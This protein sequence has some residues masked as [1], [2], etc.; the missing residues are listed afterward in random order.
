MH[1]A[2]I[3]S[4]E[5]AFKK[6]KDGEED[7]ELKYAQPDEKEEL[8][9]T[10]KMK[11]EKPDVRDNLEH[12]SYDSEEYDEEENT[13]ERILFGGVMNVKDAKIKHEPK[14]MPR[15]VYGSGNSEG[16]NSHQISELDLLLYANEVNNGVPNYVRVFDM[17]VRGHKFTLDYSDYD[18]TIFAYMINYDKF[19]HPELVDTNENPKSFITSYKVMLDKCLRMHGIDDFAQYRK[20]H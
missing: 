4:V 15:E 2:S 18:S 9:P 8:P 3:A 13:P 17:Y 19:D 10:E 20:T 11:R 6:S 12:V 14:R 16:I 1:S 5:I 7:F